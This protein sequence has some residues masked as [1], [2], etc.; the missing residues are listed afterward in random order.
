MRQLSPIELERI[1]FLT[2]KSVEFCL[3]EPTE[4]G[5]GKSIMDATGSVRSY[6]KFKNI[7][8]FERQNQGQ[9]SKVQIESFLVETDA[10]NPS[11][12][13]LYRPNTKNGDP[14]IWFKGLGNYSKANDILGLIEFDKKL[15][16]L[17]ITRLD[18]GVLLNQTFINPLKEIVDAINS[19]SNEVADELLRKL[20]K[21]AA[22]GFVPALLNADTAIGR[23]LEALLGIPMNS[24]K[25][26]DFKGIEL[27]SYRE[28]R[29]TRKGLFG[30]TPNWEL[31][32]FKSRAEILDNFGYWEKGIFRLYN[33][34]R[35]TG[36]NAQGLILKTNYELDYL[37]E[38]SDK[39]HIGDFLVWELDVLK[40][41]LLAK[42]KETFWI[43]AESKIE[44]GN[45][46]FLFKAAEHTKN[47]LIHQL[48]FLIDMGAITLDYPIKRT[49]DGS[50]IDKGCNFKLKPN[51]LD[52]LFP[53]SQ[54][55][56]LLV[57]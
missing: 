19:V 39:P 18:V 7:H 24:S 42:H 52:L 45:E 44:N 28:L 37:V 57:G 12:A 13:S 26:P 33:T 22:K 29:G 2:E 5:L 21:I 36:R 41:A 27:K 54:S 30:K 11:V 16:V 8:D 3:I 17:N 15:Y 46:F 50:V 53:Q 6:L 20:R 23:T 51:A 40:K 9:E 56:N 49:P 25:S 1:T 43:K 47:P 4:T 34:I 48:G 55:Y 35:A 31:S 38:N 10:L 32:K 14:R